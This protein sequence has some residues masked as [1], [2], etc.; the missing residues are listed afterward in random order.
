MTAAADQPFAP[1]FGQTT[2]MA[3]VNAEQTRVFAGSTPGAS[4]PNVVLTNIGNQLVFVRLTATSDTTTVSAKDLPVPAGATVTISRGIQESNTLRAIAPGGAG[5]T[6]Y[7]TLGN[8]WLFSA[9]QGGG[10][11]GVA[12]SPTPLTPV[13]AAASAIVTGGT[14]VTFVTGPINGGY[15][16]NP[17]NAA[18][19]GISVA[20]PAYI[21]LVGTPGSTDAAANGT[22]SALDPG[23]TFA[24]P[25]LAAGVTVKVNAA[26]SGHKFSVE[27][28]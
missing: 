26:T 16:T 18:R 13:A 8:G 14:A 11:G 10:G 4:A 24:L 1:H 9:G 6:L 27:V 25:A 21:S 28:W 7:I 22:T 12:P 20:E 19:Q 23:Q 5:S 2:S 3:L 15:V 17:L